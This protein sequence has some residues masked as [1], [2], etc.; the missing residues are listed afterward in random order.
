MYPSD[1]RDT[2][3]PLRLT[4]LAALCWS[5]QSEITDALVELLIG[6]VHKINA[7]AEKKVERELTEDLKR[8]R[9]KESILFR[10]AEAAVDHPDET[11]RRA[12][13]PVVGER[14]LRELVAEA[15]ANE[16]VFA[17]RVRTSLRH[18]YSNYYRRMLPPL[19]FRCNNTAYRPVMDALELLARYADVD[20]K[21][22]FYAAGERVPLE[23]V[24][25]K[26]WAEAVGPGRVHRRPAAADARGPG[27]PGRRAGG[28]LGGRGEGDRPP[29]RA[30][31]QRPKA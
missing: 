16:K 12:L 5:R 26:A 4:L 6:L 17:A 9:G 19:E 31:D 18:S 23:G 2:A 29:R 7:R 8:V 28:R 27:L 24:V 14:T 22:R 10:L 15:K 3:P 11:V 1:F 20:G 30:V 21:V 25:P 13:F